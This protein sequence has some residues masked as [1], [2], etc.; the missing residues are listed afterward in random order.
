MTA[1]IPGIWTSL[2]TISTPASLSTASNRAGNFDRHDVVGG[3][4][5]NGSGSGSVTPLPLALLP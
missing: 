3:L 5:G 1:F 2:S 4:G